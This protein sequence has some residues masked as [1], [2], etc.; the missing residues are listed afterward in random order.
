VIIGWAWYWWVQLAGPTY[1]DWLTQERPGAPRDFP[2]ALV[3]QAVLLL[4]GVCGAKV[5]GMVFSLVL[6][7]RAERAHRRHARHA[8]EA[9]AVKASARQRGGR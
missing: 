4:I 6:D 5:L 8:I 9:A 1:R 2:T 3:L 7:G